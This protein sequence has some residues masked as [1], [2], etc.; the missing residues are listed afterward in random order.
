MLNSNQMNDVFENK[1]EHKHETSE[2]MEER[3]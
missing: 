1:L 3:K 2:K